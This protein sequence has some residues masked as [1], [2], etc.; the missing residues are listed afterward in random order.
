[1][2]YP[3]SENKGAD[4]LRGYRKADL[5]LCFRMC[6][7]P[8]FSR[9]GSNDL[10]QQ[11]TKLHDMTFF[12]NLKAVE[13]NCALKSSNASAC[14]MWKRDIF[15]LKLYESGHL[16]AN[17][18]P[19]YNQKI[20]NRKDKQLA[21]SSSGLLANKLSYQ[22]LVTAI[23]GGRTGLMVRASDSGSGDPGSILG[24]V[25]VLFP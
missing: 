10:T 11:Y 17:T 15:M 25:G 22:C 5:R 8:V 14:S 6:K 23:I 13:F 16:K 2:Y 19:F 20:C 4:Q 7:K 24:R 21:A 3:Y 12:G 9:R 1:M 18:W